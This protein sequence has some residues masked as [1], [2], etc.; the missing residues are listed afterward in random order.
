MHSRS[1]VSQPG[2]P[3]SDSPSSL[4]HAEPAQ[5]VADIS[6]HRVFSPGQRHM[7]DRPRP[8]P[9]HLLS[10]KSWVDYREWIALAKLVFVLEPRLALQIILTYIQH[11]VLRIPPFHLLVEIGRASCR[12]RV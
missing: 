7:Y 4:L 3:S 6:P 5:P 11:R 8:S 2:S 1:L 9:P 10:I 12:E